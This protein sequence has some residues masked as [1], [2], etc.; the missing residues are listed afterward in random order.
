[1]TTRISI[2][3][4]TLADGMLA[5]RAGRRHWRSHGS[6]R[7]RRR[8]R[9][10]PRGCRW[11]R[12]R[13]RFRRTD[14]QRRRST[15]PMLLPRQLRPPLCGPLLIVDTELEQERRHADGRKNEIT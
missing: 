11:S 9:E 15:G 4:G 6:R 8:D 14:R 3:L 2:L 13:W 5:N 7:R 10:C 12:D 1:M